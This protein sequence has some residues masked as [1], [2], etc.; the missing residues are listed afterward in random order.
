[1]KIDLKFT[2]EMGERV[3]FLDSVVSLTEEGS[4]KADL[5]CKKTDAHLYLRNKNG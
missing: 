1:M 3:P 5:Y 4:L 2:F